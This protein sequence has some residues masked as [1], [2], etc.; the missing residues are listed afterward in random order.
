MSTF[1]S[2]F[3]LLIWSLTVYND[4][5]IG[6]ILLPIFL[7]IPWLRTRK[8]SFWKTY[9]STIV[10]AYICSYSA[11][12]LYES[13]FSAEV[14]VETQYFASPTI[15]TTWQIISDLGKNKYAFETAQG[16]RYLM[17]KTGHVLGEQLR[18]SASP[19]LDTST[20]ETETLRYSWF[21]FHKRLKMKG[22]IGALYESN[23]ILLSTWVSLGRL[24]DI[25]QNI[26]SKIIRAMTNPNGQKS[27]ALAWA[28][29]MFIGDKSVFSPKDYQTLIDSGLV[30]LVAVSG[31]NVVMLVTF[32]TAILFR[33]PFYPRLLVL[34]AAIIGYGL[35]CGMDSSV[36]RAV[37]MGVLSIFALLVGRQNV[38]RRALWLTYIVML[39]YNPY[40]LI[41]DVWFLLSFWAVW[42]LILIDENLRAKKTSE[43]DHKP[44]LSK[45][46]VYKICIY[47]RKNYIKPSVWATIGVFP[48]LLFF[49]DKINLASIGANLFV[50]PVVPLLMFGSFLELIVPQ[51]LAVYILRCLEYLWDRIIRISKFTSTH[52]IILSSDDLF[53]KYILMGW[54]LVVMIRYH[55][56][57]G[58]P[59]PPK[60]GFSNPSDLPAT[61]PFQGL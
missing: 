9:I 50:L 41:Y 19:A 45:S 39:L 10:L 40:F 27:S 55:A 30:H 22:Y 59:Q 29:W 2:I 35:V 12:F 46:P 21:N 15:T 4:W 5:S 3:S 37:I 53:I 48:I 43:D 17:S 14:G 47:P 20:S 42:W 6:I 51:K 60:G 44:K 1:I 11:Y 7:L 34:F 58:S 25:R 52:G 38:I 28:L 24:S 18:L 31:G 56:G 61:S 57:S 32:L 16:S 33:I 54:T 49:M 26:R 8:K 13:R 23:S 36:F